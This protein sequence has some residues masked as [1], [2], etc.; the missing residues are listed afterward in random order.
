[1]FVHC[2]CCSPPHFCF[3]PPHFCFSSPYFRSPHCIA[4][5]LVDLIFLEGGGGGGV[6]DK[7]VTYKVTSLLSQGFQISQICEVTTEMA[8]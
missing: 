8:V 7:A 1:M 3:S 2:F 4:L 6:L 5:F